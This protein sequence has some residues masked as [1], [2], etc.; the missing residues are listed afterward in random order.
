M[1]FGLDGKRIATP[2]AAA[3]SQAGLPTGVGALPAR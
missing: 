3:V 1:Y 2:P